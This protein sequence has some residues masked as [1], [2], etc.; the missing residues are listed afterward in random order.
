VLGHHGLRL[1]PSSTWRGTFEVGRV[2][3]PYPRQATTPQRG[4]RGRGGRPSDRRGP[5]PV[6]PRTHP[7]GLDSPPDC[8]W[9]LPPALYGQMQSN[10]PAS[11]GPR[12]N[13]QA[14]ARQ[15]CGSARYVQQ[16]AGWPV[17]QEV[18]VTDPETTP[19]AAQLAAVRETDDG[20]HASRPAWCDG[21]SAV[22]D[23]PPECPGRGQSVA[24]VATAND[25]GRRTDHPGRDGSRVDADLRVQGLWRSLLTR[26][27]P[28]RTRPSL[29]A[30]SKCTAG[31]PDGSS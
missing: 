12:V 30:T 22:G 20:D 11:G 13:L 9:H 31:T 26:T 14:Y 27:A 16:R 10:S 4:A 21:R 6:N 28:A 25:Q 8:G 17:N 3:H 5:T 19:A 29:R 23:E 15:K 1:N 24:R 18:P 2:T 7:Q